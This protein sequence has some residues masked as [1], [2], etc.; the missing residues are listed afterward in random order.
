GRLCA[1]RGFAELYAATGDPH[2]LDAAER[3]W[4]IFMDRHR[5]PTGGVMEVLK[6]NHAS[7]EGCSEG[8]WLRLNLSLWQ[9]TGKGCYLDEAERCLK[10]H[11]IYNQ[12]PNGGAG[13][14]IFHRIDG[15]QV[16]FKESGVEAWWC[17]SMHWL[18]AT[19]DV[20]RLAVTGGEQGPSI[21]LMI[22]CTG[23]VDG[24]GGKWKIAQREI[25]DGLH[26]TLQSPAETKA[27]LRI[28]RPAWAREGG[29]IETPAG[30]TLHETK[31]AWLAEGTWKG[32]QEV[33][34]HLPMDLRIEQVSGDMGAVLRG[35]DLLVA[36]RCAANAWLMDNLPG[37]IPTLLLSKAKPDKS[38]RVLVPASLKKDADPNLPEQ[39]K[40]LELA[41]LRAVAGRHHDAAWYLFHIKKTK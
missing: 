17:C 22:D 35:H 24:P 14:R 18:R 26:I 3:D 20:A 41:P 29:K 32:K 15:R 38:G 28:H 36:H 11:F 37:T 31:D 40:Q 21:N 34:V 6:R 9:L 30:L 2:W 12:Y 1:E 16:A 33:V 39:W 10:G 13:H 25:E 4:K 27:T 8:D 5:L 7:D 23:S 19:V